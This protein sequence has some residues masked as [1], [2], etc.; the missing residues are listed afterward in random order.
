M[1][2]KNGHANQLVRVALSVQ[3]ECFLGTKRARRIS[4][5]KINLL[6]DVL[7]RFRDALLKEHELI[8]KFEQ[9][10]KK[11]TLMIKLPPRSTV[12]KAV[13]IDWLNDV[14]EDAEIGID[15]GQFG[16]RDLVAFLEGG[17]T[18]LWIMALDAFTLP[19]EKVNAEA[20]RATIMDR[21]RE[22]HAEGGETEHGAMIVT[23]EGVL[24]GDPDLFSMK[25]ED[26]LTFKDRAQ[27]E[28]FIDEFFDVLKHAP[29]LDC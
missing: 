3:I 8:E 29:I 20:S 18:D 24:S 5:A 1:S 7:T 13:P 25:V 16:Q 10:R 22:I 6:I 2:R 27:A 21:L 17:E 15:L 9:A 28:N 26:A 23:I 14:P 19:A 4:I 11:N 12:K